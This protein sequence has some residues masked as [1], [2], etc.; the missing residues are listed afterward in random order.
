MPRCPLAS[1]FGLLF[2]PCTEPRAW[3]TRCPP[4][5]PRFYRIAEKPFM[6]FRGCTS[7]ISGQRLQSSLEWP[8]SSFGVGG[9]WVAERD[10]S[11]AIR[12]RSVR[13]PSPP[14]PIQEWRV[15]SSKGEDVRTHGSTNP[16]PHSFSHCGAPSPP[17]PAPPPPPPA[18]QRPEMS[19]NNERKVSLISDALASQYITKERGQM[20]TQMQSKWW[21]PTRPRSSSQDLLMPHPQFDDF[22]GAVHRLPRRFGNR[23]THSTI[24]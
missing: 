19:R 6:V 22:L 10:R 23:S 3:W 11:Y 21:P 20:K 17:R 1:G 12:A 4:L 9:L 5:A 18:V 24:R 8:H 15:P 7:K 13:P 16:Q 2:L 14:P